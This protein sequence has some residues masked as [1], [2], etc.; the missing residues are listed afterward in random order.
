MSKATRLRQQSAREKIAAQRAAARR[1][2]IRRRAL[3]T[4]GSVIAVIAIVVAFVVIKVSTNNSPSKAS[5][6]GGVTGT[7]L[8]AS[9][10]KNITTV[11]ASTLNAVGTGSVLSFNPSPITPVS[12]TPL[13]SG[14]KPEMLYIGAEFCPY[15]AAERWGMAIALS[16]FGTFSPLHGIHSSSTDTDPNTPTLTFYKST[17]TSKYLVFT[18]VENETVS[19]ALLQTPTSAQQAL[20]NK[21][22]PNSYPFVDIGNKYV[23]KAPSYDPQTLA[24]LTWAQVA[25]DLH[26][27]SSAPA[28][29]ADGTANLITAAIC[30]V[31]G[32]K[33]GNVC[34]SAGVVKA[35]GSL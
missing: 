4:A 12:N 3:I 28:Q 35:S 24:G 22:N 26:N 21:Y 33:P 16:R 34:N 19:H 29:G 23:I 8:P 6:S 9:V 25:A 30:K 11:P 13:K 15:C 2:E 1:A 31:T 27:P 20:W 5:G 10:I 18:P 32:G 7:A 14:G 17:Y